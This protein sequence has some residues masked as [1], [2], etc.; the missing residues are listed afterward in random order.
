VS[1]VAAIVS[2][3]G[4]CSLARTPTN[5]GRID[6]HGSGK[7]QSIDVRPPVKPSTKPC[8]A[9]PLLSAPQPTGWKMFWARYLAMFAP[10]CGA[11]F[12]AARRAGPPNTESMR[13]SSVQVA[14]ERARDG[15]WKLRPGADARSASPCSAPSVYERLP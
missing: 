10:S 2:L 5:T 7:F 12:S 3:V 15:Q 8:A 6:Y 1:V 4:S 13:S 11:S 9:V 14:K